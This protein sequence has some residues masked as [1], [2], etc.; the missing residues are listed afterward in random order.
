M[1]LYPTCPALQVFTPGCADRFSTFVA[2][3]SGISTIAAS[4]ASC[5]PGRLIGLPHRTIIGQ[6]AQPC[7]A[8]PCRPEEGPVPGTGSR[9]LPRI[10]HREPHRPP[11]D[12][13]VQRL[14][15]HPPLTPYP[16]AFQ[17]AALHH[18]AHQLRR[19]REL[20]GHGPHGQPPHLGTSADSARH[21]RPR[22]RTLKD[23][24]PPCDATGQHCAGR[25]SE[26]P[27]ARPSAT[28][29]KSQAGRCTR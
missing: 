23:P 10:G 22:P 26:T 18:P 20:P 2:S 3:C 13:V 28:S 7:R 29:S 12:E 14:V 21:G 19:A 5:R 11:T 17:H 8:A 25:T 4:A 9:A 16:D 6:E 27:P 1:T 24:S 15:V